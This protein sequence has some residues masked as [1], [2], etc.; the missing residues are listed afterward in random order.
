MTIETKM[1]KPISELPFDRMQ[2]LVSEYRE[3]QKLFEFC[4]ETLELCA[5]PTFG[6]DVVITASEALNDM[7]L[8]TLQER[9]DQIE[10]GLNVL[11]YTMDDEPKELQ[12]H[13]N[14]LRGE[15]DE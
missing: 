4:D 10:E 12:Y 2:K 5:E 15:D 7:L 9:L 3:I 1:L 8:R 14:V 13:V 6:S 11:G